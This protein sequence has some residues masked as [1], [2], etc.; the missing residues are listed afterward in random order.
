MSMDTDPFA[1]F[2]R[3]EGTSV[4]V[5]FARLFSEGVISW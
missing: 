5:P 1:S 2:T 3:R 4:S